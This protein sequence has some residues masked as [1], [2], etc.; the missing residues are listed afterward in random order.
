MCPGLTHPEH[1]GRLLSWGLPRPPVSAFSPPAGAWSVGGGDESV[2]HNRSLSQWNQR[3][4]EPGPQPWPRQEHKPGP[5][6]CGHRGGGR[7]GSPLQGAG[8]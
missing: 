3:K 4:E 5:C 7:E 2:K 8:G 6:S 1:K